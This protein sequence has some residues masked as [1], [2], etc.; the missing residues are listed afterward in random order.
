MSTAV[1]AVA[2]KEFD[3]A[4][5]SRLLWALVA[6]LL[7]VAA[8][9]YAGLWAAGESITAL[10]ALVF[11]GLPL[12]VLLPVAALVVG[13]MAVVGERRS[14][15][16]K[17]LLG[18]VPTRADVVFG[19]L[20]GRFGVVAAAVGLAFAVALVAGAVFFGSAPIF[21][22]LAFG[23]ITLAFG[24]AFLAIGVGISAAVASRG[25]ALALAVGSYVAFVGLWELLTAGPYYL[26]YGH[27]PPVQAA[28]W[29][30]AL[31]QFNPIVAYSTLTDYALG[32]ELLPLRLQYGLETPAA[33]GM[34]PAERYWAEI[35]FYL[36]EWFAA[37]GLLVWIVVPLGIGY[38][39]FSRADL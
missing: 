37:V 22:W 13:Y 7:V 9:G 5:R 27:G 17:L 19:T 33:I 8:V 32:V 21:D 2:R 4:G 23:A 30:L 38:Y 3:D 24:A 20:L 16:I 12:Q 39:R 18:V 31:E 1:W 26:L 6:L 15:R 11:L 28:P 29:Y 34:T 10:E 35:P 14:G 36:E 25:R